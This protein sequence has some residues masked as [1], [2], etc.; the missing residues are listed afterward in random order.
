MAIS[1]QL[2]ASLAAGGGASITAVTVPSLSSG[3]TYRDT[4]TWGESGK[5]Y[6]VME[7][8]GF[9]ISASSS[10]GV[11]M[12]SNSGNPMQVVSGPIT[13]SDSNRTFLCIE[14]AT[15]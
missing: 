8:R 11:S 9:G 3:L 4:Y 1:T 15:N 2:V 10:G 14:V 5:T 6:I 13:F 12:N 7:S